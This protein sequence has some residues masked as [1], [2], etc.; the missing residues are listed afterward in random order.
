MNEEILLELGRVVYINHGQYAGKIAIVVELLNKRK[1]II[2]G[3]G[4]GVPR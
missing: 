2:D 3:P 4:L 1:T